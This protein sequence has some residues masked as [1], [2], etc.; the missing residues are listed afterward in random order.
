MSLPSTA[1]VLVNWVPVSCMPSPESPAKR[2][3]TPSISWRVLWGWCSFA[4]LSG[5]IR[6]RVLSRPFRSGAQLVRVRGQVIDF[7]GKIFGQVIDDVAHRHD[8][9]VLLLAVDHR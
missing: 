5:S 7:Q 8:A 6:Q 2:I 4:G 9:Q 3:T 1:L